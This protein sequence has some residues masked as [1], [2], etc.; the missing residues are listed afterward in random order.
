MN[1][2]KLNYYDLSNEYGIGYTNNTNEPFY[3][4]LS[5]FNEISKYTWNEQKSGYI[6][7]SIR[8]QGKKKVIKMHRFII[9]TNNIP[10]N[11]VVDHINHNK[12]DNR[13][14]NLRIVSFAEN[15]HNYRRTSKS[16]SIYPGVYFSQNRYK[17]KI[18]VNNKQICLG[19]FNTVEEALKIKIEAEKKYFGEHRNSQADELVKQ[20]DL[21]TVI[22]QKTSR[23]ITNW[24]NEEVNVL[25]K[26]YPLEGSKCA[27]KLNNKSIN[28][29]RSKAQRL[30]LNFYN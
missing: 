20:F 8:V 12:K 23:G 5:L 9:G 27:S 30:N 25:K 17:A 22:P 2:R 13:L 29:I 18:Y 14:S 3:F 11:K 28:S 7:T 15:S 4:D 10:K 1:S 16:K 19:S 21:T 6:A 26:Y 24:S